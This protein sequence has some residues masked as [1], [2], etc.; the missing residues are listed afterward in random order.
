M[1]A[2][3]V[4]NVDVV[5]ITKREA[6]ADVKAPAVYLNDELL[7]EIKGLRDGEISEEDLF[8]VLTKANV[9]KK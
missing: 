9:P 5:R 2:A 4:F 1:N 7:A 3:D 8:I 6:S